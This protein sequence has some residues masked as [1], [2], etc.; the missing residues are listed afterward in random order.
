MLATCPGEGRTQDGSGGR[1]AGGR[2]REIGYVQTSWCGQRDEG[3]FG[4]YVRGN[5]LTLNDMIPIHTMIIR[6]CSFSMI[7]ALQFRDITRSWDC[8]ARFE[9]EK[10]ANQG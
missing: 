5:L 8:L 2:S 10:T 4:H 3:Q 7:K 1:G 9:P 6:C